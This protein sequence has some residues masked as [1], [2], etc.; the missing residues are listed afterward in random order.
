MTLAPRFQ[1]EMYRREL[2]TRVEA[3]HRTEDGRF[4]VELED[5]ILYPEGGG[6]P[7]DCGWIGELPV[8]DVQK[9]SGRIVHILAEPL[10]L[11]GEVTVRLD[12]GRRYDHMQ[13][14]TAQHVLTVL[15][16]REPG[17]TTVGFGIGSEVSYIDLDVKQPREDELRELEASAAEVIRAALPVSVRWVEREEMQRL[18]VRSRRLPGELDGPIRLVEIEGLDLNTCGGTHVA[19][20]AELETICIVGSEPMHGGTRL[21]WVAGGRVRRRTAAREALLSEL[22]RV[23]GAG[24]RELVEV[25]E[26][27]LRQL[28]EARAEVRRLRE[29]VAAAL[30]EELARRP[31]PVVACRLDEAEMLGPVAAALAGTPGETAY[32]LLAPDGAF[33][34]ALG[35]AVPLPVEEL[36]P[37]LSEALQL[38]GGGRGK[39]FRG[40]AGSPGGLEK[41]KEAL[42]DRLSR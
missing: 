23:T 14:H 19:N 33:A 4:E 30:A 21:S 10:P 16:A 8:L 25:V 2:T 39:L 42:L 9:K 38:R 36:A 17:W 28:K 11:A 7:S 3:V 37:S 24:D 22:R 34:L 40:M 6:Q 29:R 26:L 35:D 13:Q 12:W 31:G 18:P 32:L 41:A 5:T 27:K 1:R 15:A 20:T